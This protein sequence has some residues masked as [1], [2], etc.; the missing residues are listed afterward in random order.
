[1]K[2]DFEQ[3]EINDPLLAHVLGGIPH[4]IQSLPLLSGGNNLVNNNH[5]SYKY[6]LNY[7]VCKMFNI[8]RYGHCAERKFHTDEK[9]F[10][11]HLTEQHYEDSL[12]ELNRIYEHTQR[13]VHSKEFKL[14]HERF[15]TDSG[16][17]KVYRGV[18]GNYANNVVKT[19]NSA[20]QNNFQE[21]SFR[22][23]ILTFYAIGKPYY[24]EVRYMTEISLQD[25]LL[26]D[27]AITIATKS[28]PY[29]E[30][31][32]LV[33]NRRPDGLIK[34]KTDSIKFD[35]ISERNPLDRFQDRYDDSCHYNPD[36][37]YIPDY[38]VVQK[39]YIHPLARKLNNWIKKIHG[40]F[41][42]K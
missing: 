27:K 33:M 10:Y 14:Q 26:Y 19:I 1:M 17:F 29:S 13:I 36:S 39:E 5:N 28:D 30:D 3:I 9:E 8:V 32:F 24:R 2:P 16:L 23:D 40:Y 4:N 7:L 35:D 37:P 21:I 20:K 12:R 6:Y 34:V 11:L 38:K 15:F 25:I 22:T 18:Q 42:K 31:E 41:S